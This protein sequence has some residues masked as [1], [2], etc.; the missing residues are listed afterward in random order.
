MLAPT[1]VDDL[2]HDVVIHAA[3]RLHQLRDPNCEATWIRSIARTRA[4]EH[5]RR[6]RHIPVDHF[7]D[8]RDLDAPDPASRALASV[9]INEAQHRWRRLTPATRQAI[10]LLADGATYNQTATALDIPVPTVKTI[11]YRGRRTMGRT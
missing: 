8:R 4:L 7:G 10:A 9:A 3:E 11:V 1:D 6:N 2:V 5:L